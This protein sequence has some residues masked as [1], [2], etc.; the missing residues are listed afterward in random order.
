MNPTPWVLQGT[1]SQTLLQGPFTKL[2]RSVRNLNFLIYISY[3]MPISLAPAAFSTYFSI[4][5]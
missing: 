2:F 5:A 4:F 1:R 3:T